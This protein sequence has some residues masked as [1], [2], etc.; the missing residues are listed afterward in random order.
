MVLILPF[1]RRLN[2]ESGFISIATDLVQYNE[3]VGRR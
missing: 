1:W 2:S 3:W